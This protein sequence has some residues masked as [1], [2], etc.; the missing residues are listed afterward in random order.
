MS[1]CVSMEH[2]NSLH[3][4]ATPEEESATVEWLDMYHPSSN[5]ANTTVIR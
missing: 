1:Y 5:L 3:G 4:F 2:G